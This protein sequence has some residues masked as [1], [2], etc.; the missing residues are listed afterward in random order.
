MVNNSITH[1]ESAAGLAAAVGTYEYYAY[2]SPHVIIALTILAF[3][4]GYF[5]KKFLAQAQA[6]SAAPKP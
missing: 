5:G 6:M 4:S 2:A 3:L 1:L